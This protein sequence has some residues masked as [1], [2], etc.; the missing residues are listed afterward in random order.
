MSGYSEE[1]LVRNRAP[2]VV[3][4]GAEADRR[5]WAQEAAEALDAP[6]LVEARDPASLLVALARGQG[7]VYVPD[8]SQLALDVQREVVRTLREREERPKLVLGLAVSPEALL[9]KGLWRDDLHFALSR[10]RV[11]L[12]DAAVKRAVAKRRKAPRRRA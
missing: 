11:D 3:V 4:G 2:A 7:V 6:A 9:Q 10:S 12:S 8:A 1:Q 5:A